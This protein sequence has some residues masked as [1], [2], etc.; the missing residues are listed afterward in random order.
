[1]T[2]AASDRTRRTAALVLALGL[3]LLLGV[4]AVAGSGPVDYVSA[5][6]I[7]VSTNVEPVCAPGR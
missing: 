2:S 6:T 3:A 4:V 1:M 7:T 5:P